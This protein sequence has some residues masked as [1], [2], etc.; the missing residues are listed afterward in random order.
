MHPISS[1]TILV[2]TFVL[3]ALILQNAPNVAL[4]QGGQQNN[5][6]NQNNHQNGGQQANNKTSSAQPSNN[7]TTNNKTVTAGQNGESILNC[8]QCRSEGLK[9]DLHAHF[10]LFC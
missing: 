1:R 8:M 9:F 2:L 5:Q 6:N 4:A 3:T 7:T 10:S